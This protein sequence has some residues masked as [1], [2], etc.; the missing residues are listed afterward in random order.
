M[1][2]RGG[3]G[4]GGSRGGGADISVD[5]DLNSPA[6]VFAVL[7]GIMLLAFASKALAEPTSVV[8][9]LVVFGASQSG[10]PTYLLLESAVD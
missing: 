8:L 3:R 5:V 2:P 4:G 10:N 7:Y 1:A 9:F 6:I